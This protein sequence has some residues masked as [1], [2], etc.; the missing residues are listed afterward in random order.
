M[1]R[2]SRKN[3]ADLQRAMLIFAFAAVSFW[4]LVVLQ[5]YFT[6]EIAPVLLIAYGPASIGGSVAFFIALPRQRRTFGRRIVLIITG[7]F[8]VGIAF[9]SRR[10]NMQIEGLFFGLLTSLSLPVIL[11]YGIAKIFGPLVMGRIW[12]GWA[13]WYSMV[14]DLLPYKSGDR[15]ISPR[16][17]WLRYAHFGLSLALVLGLWFVFGYRDGALGETGQ[18]WFFVGLLLYHL[19]GVGLAIALHDNRAFCKYLC[20]IAVP[21]KTVSRYS[22]LKLKGEQTLCAA[23]QT[24]VCI[25]VCP[26]NI[27][28]PDYVLDSKRVLSTECTLCLE[29]MNTCPDDALKLAFGFDV[30][31]DERLDVQLP[32]ATSGQS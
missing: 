5:W 29:C 3:G 28:I 13:C 19:I 12:C 9:A 18:H 8:L 11:H 21:L 14:Y 30:G 17:G 2:A 16:S 22:L 10:G 6:G 27:R 25:K 1:M 20:P 26:M 15:L 31:G 23:C 24:Q 7:S 4:T 32:A